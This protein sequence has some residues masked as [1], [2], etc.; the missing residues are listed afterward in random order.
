MNKI[1]YLITLLSFICMTVLASPVA[2]ISVAVPSPKPG[3][4]PYVNE[5]PAQTN[6]FYHL[7]WRSMLVG[8]NTVNYL[9]GIK[10]GQFVY[11]TSGEV[12]PDNLYAATTYAEIATECTNLGI[13]NIP[14][15]V[16]GQP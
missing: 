1:V 14:P 5:V 11:S 9:T 6:A 7:Q 15:Q 16:S 2:I 4:A 3:Q 8:T 13:T 12:S 10:N